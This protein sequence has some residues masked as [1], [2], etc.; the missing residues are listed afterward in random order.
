MA[1]SFPKEVNDTSFSK[2]VIFI[3]L[4]QFLLNT[5]MLAFYFFGYHDYLFDLLPFDNPYVSEFVAIVISLTMILIVTGFL[6]GKFNARFLSAIREAYISYE[7]YVDLMSKYQSMRMEFKEWVSTQK[8]YNDVYR[9]PIEE[10]IK[11]SND[12]ATSIIEQTRQLDERASK[13]VEY[14]NKANFNSIDMA[15]E[16]SN[17][18]AS[19]SEIGS[20]IKNLPTFVEQERETTRRIIEQIKN[21]SSAIGSIK[22]IAEQTNLL[23]LNAAIEA[24]RAGDSGRGFAV[25][26]DEVRNLAKKSAEAASDIDSKI[27]DITAFVDSTTNEELI[28]TMS[29]GLDK[30]TELSQFIEQLSN[31]YDDQHRFFKTLMT[32]AKQHNQELAVGIVNLLGDIQFQDIIRQRI[33]RAVQAMDA[34]SKAITACEIQLDTTEEGIVKELDLSNI[35]QELTQDLERYKQEDSRH[36]SEVNNAH[37]EPKIEFF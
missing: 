19:L 27:S 18:T 15:S 36:N 28:D 16:I 37:E 34:E 29:Q 30:A 17:N 20:Y 1:N 31:N 25:V 12:A 14:M 8:E 7:C 26:A 3:L 4:V 23:A 2:G 33:E 22:E 9:Q 24:A 35:L 5:L 21:F 10:V 32:V 6:L 11:D 13:L